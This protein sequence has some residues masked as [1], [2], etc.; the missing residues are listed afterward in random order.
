MEESNLKIEKKSLNLKEIT[1]SIILVAI[2]LFGIIFLIREVVYPSDYELAG[3]II[4]MFYFF[5]IDIFSITGIILSIKL[6]KDKRLSFVSVLLLIVSIVC[7]EPI[8]GFIFVNG[9]AKPI[10]E[11]IHGPEI[12]RQK[13][14]TLIQKTKQEEIYSNMVNTF[15]ESQE[16][17]GAT[18]YK[19]DEGGLDYPVIILKDGDVIQIPNNNSFMPT[20]AE[21]EKNKGNR[22]NLINYINK[23]LLNK[24][25]QINLQPFEKYQDNRTGYYGIYICDNGLIWQLKE[26]RKKYN[27]KEDVGYCSFINASEIYYNNKGLYQEYLN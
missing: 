27:L 3:G 21:N 23:N 19:N 11:R 1:I 2:Q 22:V 26:I 14:Q 18:D 7:L 20:Q 12:N 10:G 5:I 24:K 25:I 9:I 15:K 4:F 6:I 13:E 17:I 8:P 16:I